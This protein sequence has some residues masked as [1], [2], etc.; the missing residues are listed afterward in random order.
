MAHYDEQREEHENKKEKEFISD[1]LRDWDVGAAARNYAI[2][3]S[4]TD[5]YD[6]NQRKAI[7]L[8]PVDC[9]CEYT[10]S[11]NSWF[12]CSIVSQSKLV[13]L[14]P[15]V[16]EMDDN[17]NGLQVIHPEAVRFRPLDWDRPR[18]P[19]EFN[20]HLANAFNELRAAIGLVNVPSTMYEMLTHSLRLIE[21]VKGG[22]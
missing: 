7:E 6:Y 13:L 2:S 20:F 10:L 9:E 21:E 8:P 1:I 22:V 11:G 4:S 5:W 19:A 14:C 18:V 15:H 16:A 3:L 17:G 12:K